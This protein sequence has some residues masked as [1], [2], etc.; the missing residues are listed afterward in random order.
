M[1]MTDLMKQITHTTAGVPAEFYCPSQL[2]L[3]CKRKWPLL[4]REEVN[5]WWNILCFLR[6]KKCDAIGRS[7]C[8][9]SLSFLFFLSCCGKLSVYITAQLG[10]SGFNIHAKDK[11]LPDKTERI[12][13]ETST[14]VFSII[15][16][17]RFNNNVFGIQNNFEIS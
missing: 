15:L 11:F 2:G 10:H 17:V 13:T 1:P 9:H 6:K 8:Y 4:S 12:N 14:S 7:F 5:I 16:M 3:C